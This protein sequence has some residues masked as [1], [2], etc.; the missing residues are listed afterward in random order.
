MHFSLTA[1]LHCLIVGTIVVLSLPLHGH[2][3]PLVSRSSIGEEKPLF[4]PWHV[5]E[6]QL[7]PNPLAPWLAD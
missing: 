7:V 1:A 4:D 6:E 2:L 5:K 3:L